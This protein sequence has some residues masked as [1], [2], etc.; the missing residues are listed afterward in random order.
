MK[1]I[2]FNKNYTENDTKLKASHLR[3]DTGSEAEVVIL[4]TAE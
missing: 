3:S 1:K 2:R 4:L